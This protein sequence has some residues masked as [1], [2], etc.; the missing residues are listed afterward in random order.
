M[1][2]DFKKAF[3]SVAHNELLAKL[4][5]FRICGSLWLWIKAYPSNRLQCVSVGQSASSLLPVLYG[6]PQ[7]SILGPLFYIIFVYG[8]PSSL[9]FSSIFLFAD[10]AK[11]IMPVS[12]ISDCH[13]LQS[14][15]ARIVK[16]S[17]SGNYSLMKINAQLLILLQ[18]SSL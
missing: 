11:C 17:A 7:G 1:Y 12:S 5:S 18:I 4:W 3:D 16:W 6:V 10:D 14:D 8:L 13:L 9:L 2:L 15:L